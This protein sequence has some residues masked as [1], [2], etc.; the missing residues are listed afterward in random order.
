[1]RIRKELWFGFS[2]MAIILVTVV[3]F[4]PWA[5]FVD[6]HLSRDDLGHLGLLMLA[7]IVVAIMLGFPTAFTLMGMGVFFGWLAYRSVNPDLAV[8]QILD[9]MVQRAYSVMSNDVLIA[10]PLFVFMGYL[11]ERANLIEK[12]FK[13]LHLSLA[14]VP[15]ALAV[16]T[17]VTCAIFATA[18]GIV[19]AVV[20]LMGLL[21]LPAMLRAGYNIKLAAGSITAGGCLGILI[22]PSVLLI[23][24]G[25]T[26]GV[27]VVKLYA[28]A[29]FP[30]LML[31]ALYVGYVIVV[32]KW[33]PHLAPPLSESERRVPLPPLSVALSA[34]TR[35]AP[36][37]LLGG[38]SVPSV[39]K[40][41]VAGQLFISL[42]P[43]IAIVAL[44]LIMY[45]GTTAP[46]VAVDTTGLVQAGGAVTGTDDEAA[47]SSGLQEPPTDEGGLQEPPKEG[48]DLKGPPPEPG[49]G[50]TAAAPSQP[51]VAAS[52]AAGNA[53]AAAPAERVPAPTW[54]WIV[55]G[56]GMIGLVL[57][58][59]LMNWQRLEIFKMLL[60]SFFPLAVMIIAVLGSIVF[61]LATP[62]EAAAVGAFG[63]LL[64]A[65]AYR[66][67]AAK[68]AKSGNAVVKTLTDLG[69][70]I[71][72][73]SFLTA[74]TSAMVCWLFVGS[75]IF[76]ASFALLGGQEII[77]RWVLSLGLT[78]LQ[79][80]LLSQFIIF[81]LGWPLE[82]TEIIVIFMPIF[83]PLLAK[84]NVDPLFF[85]LLVA[86]NLQTAFLSP[87]VAMAAFYL[88]GVSPK[89][90]TLN[91]IFAGMMPFMGIQ[92]VALLLLY[93]FPQ[94]GLWLPQTLYK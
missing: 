75:S 51:A 4:T 78:T 26:A 72:E 80:M 16:A 86:L 60:A 43:G 47:D 32:A 87:P 63:G 29:F 65:G 45:A 17:I 22:P 31:A 55:F 62:T 61:G 68:Q 42:L 28:G 93:V 69:G 67:V 88:K 37:G 35:N 70:I 66:Y 21:A 85:G 5:N 38:F 23:V 79:F 25:A 76:S 77:E 3:V 18:T 10:I 57:V 54:Y 20:T 89:H 56:L 39:S 64:L 59:G 15:G 84:F 53:A 1:M 14:R 41:Q 6:G 50:G 92:L 19:G 83:I 58:Y 13:S 73:S 81:I 71:K 82:W 48:A 91:Q 49:Q 36:A 8:Q 94:I 90:V 7:L 40:R 30:G 11:V 44:L 74:K 27:S 52:I 33:K 46:T 24:Y 9:L 34:R 12:L 2:L